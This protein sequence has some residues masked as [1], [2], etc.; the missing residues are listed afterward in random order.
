MH[1]HENYK[2]YGTVED[3]I[4]WEIAEK[5]LTRWG[6][7]ILGPFPTK[8]PGRS[9]DIRHKLK[10]FNGNIPH[11]VQDFTG[12][13]SSLVYFTLASPSNRFS[14]NFPHRACSPQATDS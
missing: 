13:R 5:P 11:K 9:Y 1:A 10:H 7:V 4:E 3:G 14:S 8:L 6:W 12:D 2:K